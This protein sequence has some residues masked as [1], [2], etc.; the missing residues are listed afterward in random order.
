MLRKITRISPSRSSD[1][2]ILSRCLGLLA[3]SS[4][5]TSTIVNTRFVVTSVVVIAS[6][7]LISNDDGVS[8]LALPPLL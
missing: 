4:T 2:R 7:L 1:A 3:P 8:R 6:F 5:R